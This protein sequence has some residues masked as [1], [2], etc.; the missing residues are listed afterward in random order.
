MK[1]PKP[2][3]LLDIVPGKWYMARARANSK[4]I[5]WQPC[6]V[7]C[8]AD[9]GWERGFVQLTFGS[10]TTASVKFAESKRLPTPNASVFVSRNLHNEWVFMDSTK[11]P[12]LIELD[13]SMLNRAV[14]KINAELNDLETR[15]QAIRDILDEVLDQGQ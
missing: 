5:T 4:D 7:I 13:V 15:K 1:K 10:W 14:S 3:R 6:K 9:S 2:I 11:Q 12:S 8:S